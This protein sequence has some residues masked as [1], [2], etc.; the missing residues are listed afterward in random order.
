MLRVGERGVETMVAGF[1]GAV[2]PN[3]KNMMNRMPDMAK[4]IQNDMSQ[5]GAPMS[6]VAQ[7]AAGMSNNDLAAIKE[8]AQLTN[9][10][11]S[12][13]IG[14]NTTQART[15][16]KHLRSARGAGNLMTGLGRA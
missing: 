10:L 15:G 2:I 4:K 1:D 6:R 7:A 12:Q 13:L 9:A 5:S 3:M 14:V 11:L 8:S 16:E